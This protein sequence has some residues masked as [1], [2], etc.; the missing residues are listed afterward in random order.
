MKKIL[1][2][3]V[4]IGFVL[5]IGI[6]IGFSDHKNANKIIAVKRIKNTNEKSLLYAINNVTLEQFKSQESIGVNAEARY[7][8]NKSAQQMLQ[9]VDFSNRYSAT[10]NCDSVN[11]DL[12]LRYISINAI[13]D[14]FSLKKMTATEAAFIISGFDGGGKFEAEQSFIYTECHNDRNTMIYNTLSGG[15]IIDF[16]EVDKLVEKL[17]KM[18]VQLHPDRKYMPETDLPVST[19]R[20]LK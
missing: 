2:F 16:D 10:T 3:I 18:D 6:F 11:K 7:Q 20:W 9:G 4:I 13:L 1:I 19:S 5:A 8:I 17:G 12:E 15:E 14:V